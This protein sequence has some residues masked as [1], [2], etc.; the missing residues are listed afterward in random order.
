MIRSLI[1]SI[2]I[3]LPMSV[4]ADACDSAEPEDFLSF[5]FRFSGSKNFSASRTI[6]PLKVITQVYGIDEMG[7]DLSVSGISYRSKQQDAELHSLSYLIQKESLIAKVHEGSPN[8][9]VVQVFGDN[10]NVGE[11]LHFSRKA[12]CWFLKEN[13]KH[14]LSNQH[15]VDQQDSSQESP[16][17]P[18]FYSKPSNEELKAT[19]RVLKHLSLLQDAIFLGAIEDAKIELAYLSESLE[20]K[21][22]YA[23]EGREQIARDCRE[24]LSLLNKN[25]DFDATSL[26]SK[27]VHTL[28]RKID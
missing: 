24:A 3:V 5:F 14:S 27:I 4:H 26:L 22:E 11:T 23:I 7:S 1:L 6:Y 25:R 10:P 21:N 17:V 19:L 8:Y 2:L 12:N 15:W 18:H 16:L 13:R 20:A 28:W 9:F